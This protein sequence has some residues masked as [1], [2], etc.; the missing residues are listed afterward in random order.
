LPIWDRDWYQNWFYKGKHPPACTCADCTEA[1]LNKLRKTRKR[2]L[3]PNLSR[4]SRHKASNRMLALLLP[5]IILV[6]GVGISIFI[7]SYIP[8]LLSFGFSI[9][10][11]VEKW[12]KSLLKNKVIGRL[13]R[14]ILNLGILS[15]FGYL[16]WSGIQLFSHKVVYS[17]LIGSLLFIFGVVLFIYM[18]KIVAKNSWRWPS[19]KLTVFSLSCLFLVFSF[20]GVQ[21]ME[22]YKNEVVDAITNT[23]AEWQERDNQELT[24]TEDELPEVVIQETDA[25]EASFFSPERPGLTNPSWE[26]LKT[27]L[28]EDKTDQYN[29]SY[30]TFVCA[31]FASTLQSN[32]ENAGFRCAIVNVQLNGYPDWFNYGIPSNTGHA[33]NAFDTTDRGLVYIDCTGLPSGYNGPNNCDKTV[34]AKI[35]TEYVP[36]SIFP[37]LLGWQWASMGTIVDIDIVQ[38]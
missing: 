35:G 33:L 7:R 12:C 18:W 34:D 16:I 28:L 14:L 21:P 10:F 15:L 29:Y 5:F 31:D 36:R 2:N 38:W 24:G 23:A 26:E 9:I 27:F 22:D 8:F 1:R 11:S 13:Y 37:E 30:P 6:I 3:T 19:M 17:P 4:G 20:A 25:N 32:A